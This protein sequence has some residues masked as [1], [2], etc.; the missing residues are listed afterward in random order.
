[1]PTHVFHL[2]GPCKVTLPNLHDKM[3]G[4]A[5]PIFFR[6]QKVY[7]YGAFASRQGAPLKSGSVQVSW[8]PEVRH[9]NVRTNLYFSTD[10][11]CFTVRSREPV[12]VTVGP[13][14]VLGIEIYGSTEVLWKFQHSLARVVTL[15]RHDL[16][17]AIEAWKGNP[18]CLYSSRAAI[19]SSC[20][21]E[22]FGQPP[23]LE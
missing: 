1:M 9:F 3:V 8:R 23:S 18:F 11:K 19:T 17:T 4:L 13:A 5:L 21:Y 10:R 7:H 2:V 20:F 16:Y 14:I 15:E 22:V 12:R 6:R